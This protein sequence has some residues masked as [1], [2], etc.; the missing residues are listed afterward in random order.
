MERCRGLL[1][2]GAGVATADKEGRVPLHLA[3]QA[4]APGIVQL[5]LD[6]EADPNSQDKHGT[7]PMDKADYWYMKGRGDPRY[8]EA[9]NGCVQVMV[10]LQRAGGQRSRQGDSGHDDR[11]RQFTRL[12]GRP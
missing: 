4:G 5:L 11:M 3:S 9:S 2:H 1:L 6:W 10:L 8:R 7:R 12:A